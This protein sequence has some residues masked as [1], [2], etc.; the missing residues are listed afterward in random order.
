ML[1]SSSR[2]VG[3]CPHLAPIVRLHCATPV[4]V[5]RCF[6]LIC[7]L[8]PEDAVYYGGQDVSQSAEH[9]PLLACDAGVVVQDVV[10]LKQVSVAAFRCQSPACR[11][12]CDR[13]LF[14]GATHLPPRAYCL[15][16][17]GLVSRALPCPGVRRSGGW[18]RLCAPRLV[19]AA[20]SSATQH[21]LCEGACWHLIQRFT[22]LPML[23]P[24][25]MK[26]LLLASVPEGRM[27][28]FATVSDFGGD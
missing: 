23:A 14:E 12:A 7:L 24:S 25:C 22:A 11:R 20:A 15:I 28:V 19:G 9:T 17:S 27:H 6:P 13:E 4:R 5:L 18:M 16:S 3:G 2:C 10:F 1:A 8:V 21:G 26:S